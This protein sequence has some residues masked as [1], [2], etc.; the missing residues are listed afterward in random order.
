MEYAW[1]GNSKIFHKENF[2]RQSAVFPEPYFEIRYGCPEFIPRSAAL[3]NRFTPSIHAP[4]KLKSATRAFHIAT[5]G[6]DFEIKPFAKKTLPS[7][8]EVAMGNLLPGSS[9]TEYFV[10]L[11]AG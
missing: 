8:K 3:H 5:S 10:K 7:E 1:F 6:K 9:E 4:L 11:K 2:L